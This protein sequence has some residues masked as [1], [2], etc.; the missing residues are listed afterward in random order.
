MQPMT[1]SSSQS[2]QQC[3]QNCEDCHMICMRTVQHCLSMGGQ[4]ADPNHIVLMLDCA[5]ICRTSADFMLR[6]SPRHTQVCGLCAQT[7]DQCAMDCERIAGGD[8]MMMDCVRCCRECAA[9]C[10]QM[11]SSMS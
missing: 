11:A 9:A 10:R 7:C 8:S 5:D 4:H 2:M 1:T 3:I 6:S